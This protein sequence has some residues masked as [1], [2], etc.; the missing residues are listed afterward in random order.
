MGAQTRTPRSF[1]GRS[2]Q[3]E[4]IWTPD[5]LVVLIQTGLGENE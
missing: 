2:K 4:R 1:F 3:K 5:L